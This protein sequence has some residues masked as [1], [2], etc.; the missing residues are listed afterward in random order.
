M[1][2]FNKFEFDNEINNMKSNELFTEK[3]ILFLEMITKK[4]LIQKNIYLDKGKFIIFL[5]NDNQC[6]NNS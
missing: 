1:L 4:K 6:S 2:I 3:P 5:E